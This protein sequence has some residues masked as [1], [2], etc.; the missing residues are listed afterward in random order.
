MFNTVLFNKDTQIDNY[1]IVNPR[2]GIR[3]FL[4]TTYKILNLPQQNKT[5]KITVS[6]MNETNVTTH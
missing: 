5:L 3:E 6:T 4:T 2:E 1:N